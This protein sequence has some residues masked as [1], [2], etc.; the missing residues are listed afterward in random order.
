MCEVGIL[1]TIGVN[2]NFQF[3][4]PQ[5]SI[6]HSKREIAFAKIVL[7]HRHMTT[8]EGFLFMEHYEERGTATIAKGYLYSKCSKQT[9][10]L[11]KLIE[12]SDSSLRSE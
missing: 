2:F 7:S 1:F 6:R 11:K 9:V 4:M 5:A 10:F 3:V 8:F 12:Q